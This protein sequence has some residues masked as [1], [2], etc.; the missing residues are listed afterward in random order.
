MQWSSQNYAKETHDIARPH[1][2]NLIDVKWHDLVHA[3]I[4][5]YTIY[6]PDGGI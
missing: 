5:V 6:T 4:G 2:T 1:S 3:R